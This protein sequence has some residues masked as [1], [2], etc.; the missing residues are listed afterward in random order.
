[1]LTRGCVRASGTRSCSFVALRRYY[2]APEGR[3]QIDRLKLKIPLLGNLFRK[4]AAANL[5]GSLAGLI[6]GGLPI[7]QALQT[8]S[9]VCG[10]E[11][12]ARAVRTAAENVTI[13]RRLSDELERSDQ[14]PL[15]VVRMIS[16]AEDVGTP[17]E[18]LR[19][20]SASY[21]E[22]VEYTIRRVMGLIE[23]IVVLCVGGIVGFV[24]VALYYPIFNLGNVFLSGA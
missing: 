9:K 7:I 14:F 21:I 19:Q 4:S 16:I 15:M 5:T 10:N 2:R 6:D 23:P 24:L 22:E 18:V 1:M 3:L 20:I 8:A 17:P 12:M 13:G 11:L